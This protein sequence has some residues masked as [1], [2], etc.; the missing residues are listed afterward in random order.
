MSIH[1]FQ[2]QFSFASFGSTFQESLF[3]DGLLSLWLG[4]FSFLFLFD[5]L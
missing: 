4:F 3:P 5:I 1:M 2:R